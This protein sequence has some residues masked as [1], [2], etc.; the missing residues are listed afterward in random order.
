MDVLIV[1]LLLAVG[2]VI[3]A[4]FV[5]LAA[6]I[7][8]R[9]RSRAENLVTCS[10]CRGAMSVEGVCQ[11]CGRVNDGASASQVTRWM[12]NELLHHQQIDS[13][14]Y[15]QL[16]TALQERTAKM[17]INLDSSPDVSA[18]ENPATSEADT[19]VAVVAELVEGGEQDRHETDS[20]P[21]TPIES[22]NVTS[23]QQPS[24]FHGTDPPKE[25]TE[26]AS[27]IQERVAAYAQN[28]SEAD[29][30]HD[31]P[32]IEQKPARQPWSVWFSAFLEEKNIRWGELVGGLL[33]VSGTVALVISF[34]SAIAERPLL[35]FGVLNGVTAALFG[36]GIHAARRWKLTTTSQGILITSMLL[37]P[38]NFLAIAAFT[39][40]SETLNR[41]TFA[42]ESLS[43][44][45]LATL[46]FLAAR[47]VT[48]RW[49]ILLL[50]GIMV[51]S[52]TQLFIRR[53]ISESCSLWVLY[54][55]STL[56]LL[57][58][59]CLN[60]AV[61]R[62]FQHKASVPER[63]ANELLKHLGLLAFPV[64]TA[65]GLF[66]VKA[67]QIGST[68][69]QLSPLSIVASF[70]FLAVGLTLARH[71]GS[72]NPAMQLV[73]RTLLVGALMVFV[74]G[75]VLAWPQPGL[76]ICL[77]LIGFLA[78]VYLAIDLRL[79]D[80][81]LV[82]AVFLVIAA[83]LLSF[84]TTGRLSW[85]VAG[86]TETINQLWSAETGHFLNGIA[87]LGVLASGL[88]AKFCGQATALRYGIVSVGSAV[89][90]IAIL[91]V[92]GLGQQGD[93]EHLTWLIGFY[94]LALFAAGLFFR[95]AGA[96]VGGG[97]LLLIVL[98]QAF[99]CGG[100][101]GTHQQPALLTLMSHASVMV[102]VGGL[103]NWRLAGSVPVT[104]RTYASIWAV[105]SSSVAAILLGSWLFGYLVKPETPPTPGYWYWLASV[106][107][108]LAGL[109]QAG[110]LFVV[111]QTAFAIGCMVVINGYLTDQLWYG[112]LSH[113]WLH[114]SSLQWQAIFL[115]AYGLGWIVLRI[116]LRASEGESI[117]DWRATL[118]ASLK[119]SLLSFDGCAIGFSTAILLMLT[120]YGVVPGVAQELTPR[121][122]GSERIVPDFRTYE[123]ASIPHHA[124]QVWPTWVLLAVLISTRFGDFVDRRRL[125]NLVIGLIVLTS[126][127]PLLIAPHWEA[128]VAVASALRWCSA[129]YFLVGSML[130]CAWQPIMKWASRH[131]RCQPTDLPRLQWYALGCMA[132]LSTVPV[133]AMAVFAAI[134]AV[135]LRPPDET[136]A[137]WLLGTTALFLIVIGVS[138]TIQR[139]K[140][141]LDS[142]QSI[143]GSLAVISIM[144]LTAITLF[145]VGQ[146]F[147]E[148]PILG[149]DPNSF[150]ANIGLA[151]SY[152]IPLSMMSVAL[153]GLAISF[154]SGT[155]AL[156][157]GLLLN[158][159]ATA[160][161][162]L[163]GAKSGFDL[164]QWL[165]IAQL[166]SIVAS[167][168][169][170]GWLA[171]GHV[172]LRDQSKRQLWY[173]T[174][175]GLG[176]GFILIPLVLMIARLA[177]APTEGVALDLA[178]G[179]WGWTALV[180][181]IGLV[182][183]YVR[184]AC[185]EIP[186]K[187]I[188]AATFCVGAMGALASHQYDPVRL[189][190]CW[191][192]FHV[193][194]LMAMV[195]GGLCCTIDW[196][197]NSKSKGRLKGE[198]SVWL[199][200][201]AGVLTYLG[202]RSAFGDPASP[203]WSVVVWLFASAMFIIQAKKTQQHRFAYLAALLLNAT[204]SLWWIEV[205]YKL[206][207]GSGR[208]QL[209]E[210]L[211]VN[212][213]AAA[214]PVMLW[215]FIFHR[216][217]KV[218][219]KAPTVQAI[220]L[221]FSI[222]LYALG[223]FI[224]LCA[225]AVQSPLNLNPW[226]VG[227]GL[228][229]VVIASLAS[230]WRPK[231]QFAIVCCYVA[232][233]LAMATLLD[234]FDQ[235]V[236]PMIWIGTLLL[237][238]YAFLTS[239]LWS[240]RGG[241]KQVAEQMRI[242]RTAEVGAETQA[243][244]IP[245]NGILA[246]IVCSLAVWT[247]F[248]CEVPSLRLATSQAIGAIAFALGMLARGKRETELRYSSLLFGVISVIAFGWS[249]IDPQG[250]SATLLNRAVVFASGI[251]VMAVFYGIGFAKIV[252]RENDWTAAARRLVPLLVGVGVASIGG[253]LGCEV[254]C[255]AMIG[256]TDMGMPAILAVAAAL[257]IA[258]IACLIA[259]V[260]PGRDP[261]GL[262]AQRRTIYVYGAEAMIALLFLH[263]R[264]TM[265]HLFTG[266]FQEYWAL[267]VMGIAFGGVGLGEWFRRR[268]Q[269]V[270]SQPLEKTGALLPMLPVIGFWVTDQSVN[271]SV[272]MLIVGMSYAL[273]AVMRKSF[274]FGILAALAANGGLWYFLQNTVQIQFLLHPQLW[275]IPGAVCVLIA[276]Y[277]SRNQLSRSQ[278]SAIRYLASAV[279]YS[280]STADIFIN[281]VG[282]APWLPVML[283]G[284]SIVGIFAG[285]MMRV[286]AFLFLGI[287]F[288]LISLLSVVW[289]AAVDLE[290]TWLWYAVCVAAGVVIIAV[291]AVF[292]RKRQEVFGLV[293][294]LKSWDG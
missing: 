31:Q 30:S 180:L 291:F 184:V 210:F 152:A 120:L 281:G 193:L 110:K 113:G 96:I 186:V 138:W 178:A 100:F 227:A 109:E 217:A 57:P 86:P 92:F 99:Y 89:I 236:N 128:S 53:H 37:V 8:S 241:I 69:E 190:S 142:L 85:T 139:I 94:T 71:P 269:T 276:A 76:M 158:F 285:I 173:Q 251:M 132:I 4:V 150:F 58:F 116:K 72:R 135:V 202:I 223:V 123:L 183:S 98:Y 131:R 117:A 9:K 164:V 163:A 151:A 175:V 219:R 243:W 250:A 145:V 212:A 176:V 125:G 79:P 255:Y 35:K 141:E 19:T 238:A 196:V 115:A 160:A 83:V 81:H 6:H 34:W 234:S 271:Y 18:R 118:A 39:D 20:S 124:V 13:Q 170:F 101:P 111:F 127:I 280:S 265:P 161:Y 67:G 114:P 52:V 273:L 36:V 38:L 260:V 48:P 28:R 130:L 43:T 84:C 261:L 292:E 22:A 185:G 41:V 49:P 137:N 159:S 148:H 200:T 229:A 33:I 82:A 44:L 60:F 287:S 80:C 51:P 282:K 171:L 70:P 284:L 153:I 181:A 215:V 209:V 230:L 108:I 133:F 278:M 104:T 167:T 1:L 155:I 73:G 102:L 106:S 45:L 247:Q 233:L 220:G 240:R 121:L 258:L 226:P 50:I 174:Q 105:T 189:V 191:R 122:A 216:S 222:L 136:Q 32:E 147:G 270:L 277:M 64:I 87:L 112:T 172:G 11:Q 95:Q 272:L 275:L 16:L 59:A 253:I 107:L 88:I 177:L 68:L 199:V 188:L 26:T 17:S 237:A 29:A 27:S 40:A 225:D 78:M 7:D 91:L 75:A 262:P 254:W 14:T 288:L 192:A 179:W 154:R 149:P 47:I 103:A 143:L 290:Q 23:S 126:T 5:V 218:E 207:G 24:D 146:A 266:F 232:G 286:R 268:G 242:P 156:T 259:A 294:R 274:G 213:C 168:Y 166:N 162:L 289:Y 239:Y 3:I 203:W 214:L 119:P 140:T 2:V 246:V 245:C 198:L 293:D 12:L 256:R 46:V 197:G 55:L 235:H 194:Q 204:V 144:P 54:G 201:V 134:S 157:A 187:V 252:R 15:D 264:V 182:F 97:A 65:A 42:G 165:R 231:N 169:G 129:T 249:W 205:G 221:F 279:I 93:P 195:W 257:I 63:R 25:V 61:A 248:T 21:I 283:A 244:L 10:V 263:F 206:T 56:C 228:V 208:E 90:S 62:R 224:G 66:L 211:F 74:A 77:S 267:V